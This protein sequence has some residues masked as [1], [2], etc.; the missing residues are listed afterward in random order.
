VNTVSTVQYSA[1]SHL[2]GPVVLLLCLV[3]FCPF[4]LFLDYILWVFNL[5]KLLYFLFFDSDFFLILYRSYWG[6]N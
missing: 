2:E 5:L 4:I 1:I 6:S 3:D